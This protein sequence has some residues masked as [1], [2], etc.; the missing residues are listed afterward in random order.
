MGSKVDYAW[1]AEFCA[2]ST[3]PWWDCANSKALSALGISLTQILSIETKRKPRQGHF[4][5]KT[6]RSFV[7]CLGGK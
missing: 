3:L 6:G 2:D 7:P 1:A 4:W 5:R